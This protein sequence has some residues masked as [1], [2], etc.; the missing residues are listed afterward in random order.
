MGTV[1]E[2]KAAIQNLPPEDQAR[3]ADWVAE[4]FEKDWDRQVAADIEAGKLGAII[5]EVD[6]DARAGDRPAFS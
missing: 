4:R 5:E 1:D 6:R 2:I 3:L